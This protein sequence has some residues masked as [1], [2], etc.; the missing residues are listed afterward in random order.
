MA[1]PEFDG[2]DFEFHAQDLQRKEDLRSE[3]ESRLLALAEGHDDIIGASVAVT[4]ESHGETPHLFR[5]RVVAY[6]RPENIAAVEKDENPHLALKGA[7]SALERQVR[8]RR[9][10]LSTRWQQP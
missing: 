1:S 5:A 7:L 8:E 2:F 6:I 3:A 10:R 4:R 9:D